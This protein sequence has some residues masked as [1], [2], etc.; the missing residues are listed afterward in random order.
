MTG[1]GNQNKNDYLI[2]VH[3]WIGLSHGWQL[4]YTCV[5]NHT[6][7]CIAGLWDGDG[8]YFLKFYFVR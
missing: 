1:I 8:K 3:T 7:L 4:M 2:N 5:L 6:L